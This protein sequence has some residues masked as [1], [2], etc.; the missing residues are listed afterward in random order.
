MLLPTSRCHFIAPTPRCS[1]SLL[2]LFPP[3]PALSLFFTSQHSSRT[4]ASFLPLHTAHLPSGVQLAYTDSFDRLT[5]D[6]RPKQFTTVIAVHGLSFGARTSNPSHY[7]LG[8]LLTLLRRS[9][10]RLA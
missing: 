3:L 8:T 6:Q 4:M 9:H 2:P 5:L 10:S 1:P 7:L